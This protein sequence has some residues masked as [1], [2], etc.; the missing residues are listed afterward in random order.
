MS[1]S[2]ATQVL[3]VAGRRDREA[4]RTLFDEH[5]ADTRH[6]RDQALA[7]C[8]AH[9][10]QRR[11]QR[12]RGGTLGRDHRHAEELRLDR[13]AGARIEDV[14]IATS[15]PLERPLALTGSADSALCDPE[16]E[17]GVVAVEWIGNDDRPPSVDAAQES[18]TA[19]SEIELG[20]RHAART[21]DLQR[22]IDCV[23]LADATEIQRGAVSQRNR[24][25]IGLY[26]HAVASDA[27][28]CAASSLRLW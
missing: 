18:E 9:H 15:V 2:Q 17:Q 25:R 5:R 12:V 27:R 19:R 7:I 26:A 13:T 22:A 3:E 16:T 11:R 1:V 8:R 14:A 24:S 4:A 23:S 6:S 20:A 21:Q 10:E 28:G